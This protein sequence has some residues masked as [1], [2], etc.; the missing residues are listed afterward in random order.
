MSCPRCGDGALSSA[1]RCTVCGL[2]V[3]AETSAGGASPATEAFTD[4]ET[5][6]DGSEVTVVSSTTSSSASPTASLSVGQN[7]GPRYHI[8]RRLGEGGMGAVYQAWDEELAVVVA[9]KVIRPE[10]TADPSTAAT[11]SGASSAS[12]CWLARS[13]TRTW[14]AST[15]SAR[16]TASS[17]SRCRTSTA[18]IWR[19]SCGGGAHAGPARDRHSA[20]GC[21]EGSPP[22][23]RRGRAP[24]S[25]ARQH[26]ARRR[27]PCAD[28][29][30]RH[31]AVDVSGP[32]GG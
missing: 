15:T 4:G 3:P 26:H 23:T 29:G 18:R 7:F 25:E 28:Y 27:G 12:C 24:R 20:A 16:S 11:W 30:L 8:I 5:R 9:I 13:P 19:P 14:C 32:G 17:T 21:V 2:V 10:S 6:Y 22:R 31:R 1:G